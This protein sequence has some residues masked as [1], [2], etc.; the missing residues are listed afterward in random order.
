MACDV[1]PVAMFNID[2]ILVALKW[3]GP[4]WFA[5]MRLFK[6]KI[7]GMNCVLPQEITILPLVVN[8]TAVG[9]QVAQNKMIFF[10]TEL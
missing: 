3:W 4:S 1:S 8:V 7:N 2:F 10:K 5:N 9:C 6:A